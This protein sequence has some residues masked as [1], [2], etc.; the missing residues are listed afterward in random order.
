[1]KNGLWANLG[2]VT[3]SQITVTVIETKDKS[4]TVNIL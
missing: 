3:K 4:I 1:M 2:Q